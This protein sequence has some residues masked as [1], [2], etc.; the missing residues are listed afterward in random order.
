MKWVTDIPCHI[1]PIIL[2]EHR[3][4]EMQMVCLTSD[5]D[6]A[7][8]I[9]V[10]HRAGVLIVHQRDKV[11]LTDKKTSGSAVIDVKSCQGNEVRLGCYKL[12]KGAVR[13][14]CHGDDLLSNSPMAKKKAPRTEIAKPQKELRIS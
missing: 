2:V 9:G 1:V 12:D 8:D 13:K 11:I 3:Q 10:K 4:L 6:I 5:L 14:V 7:T